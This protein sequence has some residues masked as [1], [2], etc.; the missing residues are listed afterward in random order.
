MCPMCLAAWLSLLAGAGV[1]LAETWWV[2]VLL[3]VFWAGAVARLTWTGGRGRPQ[4]AEGPAR[5]GVSR[6]WNSIPG[7]LGPS[8]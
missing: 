7:G 2:R 8:R 4:Q 1:S 5:E 3:V 6:R